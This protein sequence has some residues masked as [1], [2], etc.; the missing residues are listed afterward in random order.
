MKKKTAARLI[1]TQLHLEFFSTRKI[2]GSA[3]PSHES[4]VW[5]SPPKPNFR[6]TRKLGSWSFPSIYMPCPAT[7]LQQP[8]IN[9][10]IKSIRLKGVA[11]RL[12]IV[13]WMSRLVFVPR[14]WQYHHLVG[15]RQPEWSCHSAPKWQ[16]VTTRNPMG[17]LMVEAQPIFQK[18]PD[19]NVQGNY[20]FITYLTFQ[21][22]SRRISNH[23]LPQKCP[24]T[25]VG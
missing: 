19:S 20:I 5:S 8:Q 3:R 4:L 22:G 12:V 24:G 2:D 10:S 14:H 25:G 6:K 11:R 17:K 1:Y 13:C 23:R 7:K 15:L 9:P 18:I 21:K 16:H